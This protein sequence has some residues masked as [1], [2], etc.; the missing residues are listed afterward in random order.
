MKHIILFIKMIIYYPS[1]KL[2]ALH[3]RKD[4]FELNQMS[5]KTWAALIL[6]LVKVKSEIRHVNHIPLEDGFIFIAHHNNPYDSL[7]LLSLFPIN[8]SFILD[9]KTKIP[10]LSNWFKRILTLRIS[11]NYD[12]VKN[13]DEVENRMIYAGNL[14]VY[15]NQLE[16]LNCLNEFIDY[17]YYTKKTLIPLSLIN[18]QDIMRKRGYY[19]TLVDIGLPLHYEE[20]QSM[21]KENCIKEIESR[22]NQSSN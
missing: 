13:V 17:A 16:R 8:I 12:F 19:K 18:T 22:I 21:S 10:F 14:I 3:I 1:I 9:E 20:Y 7:L 11:S 6:K 5:A 2:S 4:D 15:S